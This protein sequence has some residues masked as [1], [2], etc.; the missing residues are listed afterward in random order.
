MAP[1]NR[2]RSLKSAKKK[3]E[4]AAVS[5]AAGQH[6]GSQQEDRG[7]DLFCGS[8]GCGGFVLVLCDLRQQDRSSLAAG[9]KDHPPAGGLTALLRLV[10]DQRLP[11]ARRGGLS[12]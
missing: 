12:V 5:S 4:R 7:H 3:Q 6:G 8:A 2:R 11:A 9:E 10:L 1:W